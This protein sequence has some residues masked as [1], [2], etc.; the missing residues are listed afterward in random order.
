MTERPGDAVEALFY[1]AADLPPAERAAF[2]DTACRGDPGLR[3]EVE[4]LLAYDRHTILPGRRLESPVVRKAAT[5]SPGAGPLV[6]GAGVPPQ[7]GLYRML[8]CLG[9]GGM[10]VVWM[11][12]QHEPVRRTVAVKV[13]RAG[14][15]SAPVVARFEAERQALALMDHPNIARVLDGG[16]TVDGRPYLVMELVEGTPITTYCDE[17]RLTPRQRLELFVPVC[18][19]LQHAHQ[20]GIIHRDIKPSNVLVTRYD[21]RPVVKVIDFG[22]A[23]AAGPRLTEQTLHTEFGAVLGT[24]EYMSPEQAELN[25]HDIDTRSD[26]YSLGVLLY[27]LLTGTTPLTAA[28]VAHADFLERLRVIREEEP[29][30]PSTRTRKDEGGR[31]KDERKARAGFFSSFILHPSSFQEMDWIVMKALEKDRSRRYDTANGLARDIERY[32]ADEP[33]EACPPS[34][35]YRLRK[36]LRRYRGRVAAAGAV[37]AALVAGLVGTLLF[38]A[39]EAEQRRQ[40]DENARLAQQEKNA[41]L[42]QTYRAR[43]AAA[44][45]ALQNH[46]VVDVARQLAEAPAGLRGWEWHYLHARLDDS[47]AVIPMGKH[48]RVRLAHTATG[49]R[50]VGYTGARVRVLDLDGRELLARP[51]PGPGNLPYLGLVATGGVRFLEQVGDTIRLLDE[52]G[53][54]RAQRAGAADVESA[55]CLS[56]DGSWLA[57]RTR[58]RELLLANLGAGPPA[59]RRIHPGNYTWSASLSPD[60]ARFVTG[61]EDGVARVWD[62]ATGRPTA[63]CRGHRLK[64]LSVAFRPDGRRVVTASADGSVRQWDPATGRE[65]VP[66]YERHTGE[67]T[68]AAYSPDGAWVVSGGT[69]RTVRV[70]GAEDRQEVAVL[71]GHDGPVGEV[72]FDADGRRIV[73]VG[74]PL[75]P[76]DPTQ[77]G[78]GDGTVLRWEVQPG[79]GLP[80]LRGHTSY[81]YPVAYSPDGRWIASASWDQTVRLWDAGTGELAATWPLEGIGRNLAFGPDGSWLVVGTQP[82]NSQ[83]TRLQVWD[84]ATGRS[85]GSLAQSDEIVL[86]LAVS[87]DGTRIATSGLG[88]VAVLDGVS[89]RELASWPA[90]RAWDEKRALTYSPDGRRLVATG[91]DL[92][93][94]DVWEAATFRRLGRLVGH[95]AP[96]YVVVFSPDGRRLASTGHDR[97]VRIWDVATGE[98]LAVLR[99]H[100]DQVFAAAFHPDGTRLATAGRDRAVWLWDVAA[101]QE[102]ARLPGHTNY[103][104]SLAFRPDGKSLVSGSGD[105]TVR[106]WDTAPLAERYRARR[107]AEA[108]RPEAERL[109]ER[110]FRAK[111][112][113]AAVVAALRADGSLT[114]SRRHA[115]FRAMLRRNSR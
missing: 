6:D 52:E 86:S 8:R 91:D 110:L 18:R 15:D 36:F 40:A 64:V 56:P 100:T 13:I 85:G 77:V 72:Q 70:W 93:V 41:T 71:H 69:D 4:S 105:G 47:A 78:S 45:A 7:L 33:V 80:V 43:L 58:D 26:V 88:R 21:G 55:V 81:V 60:R 50:V 29:S 95:T 61:G 2:L 48:E 20:K 90:S 102:V 38:A 73:S 99:G 114:E 39:G 107:A 104:F 53:R 11:A 92:T 9:E 66:P 23:K 28:E 115:A 109:V 17:Q 10:G 108:L 31:M 57:C 112:D 51:S 35:G 96:V 97:T 14:I 44:G 103:V 111:N 42:Y 16:T 82:V 19:A 59:W 79:A 25:N 76:H 32:L 3:A 62:S 24:L 49:L 5:A 89:G 27:E 113:A 37:V 67:A 22:I 63:A 84:V 30:R 83:S 68:T 34:A 94:I 98:C 1:R 75:D 65:T 87:P 74:A 46:D 54:V 12:E 101:G 106:L